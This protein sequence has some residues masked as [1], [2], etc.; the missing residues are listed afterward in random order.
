[1]TKTERGSGKRNSGGS[2]A[3]GET[4]VEIILILKRG[5]VEKP[6]K[7]K[8][9]RNK[10]REHSWSLSRWGGAAPSTPKQKLK[11]NGAKRKGLAGISDRGCWGGDL[12]FS[13]GVWGETY[14]IGRRNIGGGKGLEKFAHRA[15]TTSCSG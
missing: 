15:L 13:L 10:R 5:R 1:M 3:G 8:S 4:N 11:Q 2:S 7:H 9:T 6:K 14:L 12:R